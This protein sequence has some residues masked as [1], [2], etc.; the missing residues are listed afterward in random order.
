MAETKMVTLTIEGR[1]AVVPEGTSILEAAKTVGI[2]IPHYCYHPGLPVAGSCRMCLVEVEKMPKLAPACA[3]A[4]GEGQVVQMNTEKAREARASV[5]EFLL[6]NHPLDCPICDKSGECE[7][8]DFTF[9]EGPAVSRLH[10]PKRF[11]PM[12][13]FGGD[14]LYVTNR[15]ILCTR[16][17]RFMDA[18]AEEPVL[19]VSERGDR[20]VI[21]VYEGEGLTHAW[22]SNVIDLCPVGALL[23]KDSLNKARAWELDRTASVCP[24]CSQGCNMMIESRDD[25][26]ARLRP[27]PNLEVN[28]YYMCDHGR[29]DYRWMNRP[30]R[31]EV[32]LVRDGGAL[33]PAAWDDAL[34]AAASLIGDRE[35]HV[36]ASPNLP[37]ETLWLLRRLVD[38]AGGSAT[39]RC[40]TGD[41]APLPGVEDLALRA[42]RGA[43]VHGALQLGFSRVDFDSPL[44][45][46]SSGAVLVVAD[47]E[48]ADVKPEVLRAAASVLVI[49]TTTGVPHEV[50]DVVLPVANFA[51][52]EGTFTNLRG[53]VQR[54]LQSRGAPGLARPTWFVLSELLATMGED[55]DYFLASEVF[56]G[57]A[58]AQPAFAGLSYDSLGLAGQ[59]IAQTSLAGES[60]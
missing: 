13:D 56:D 10:E 35:V 15:C 34:A 37:N 43:N 23:S 45:G 12:E 8:Q 40:A 4:V 1:Q 54:F 44:A 60:A 11:N 42:D 22:A 47:D 29:L 52:E 51:E 20:A 39:F 30:D 36:L 33:Q 58:A 28:E 24:G 5:L 14:V 19:N 41:E 17:V 48:L 53:R 46:V 6:I 50:A 38:R 26:I 25:V 59:Q 16:C 9:A 32:P 7:L 27:R 49:G 31:S 2:L 55:T 57:L 18:V 21:G 3:T